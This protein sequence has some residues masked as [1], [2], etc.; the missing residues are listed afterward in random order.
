M[1]YQEVKNLD[2]KALQSELLK[3]KKEY[4]NLRFQKVLGELSNTSRIREVKKN[5]ARIFTALNNVDQNKVADQNKVK[6]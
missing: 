3:Y 4:F 2:N 1:K 5:I 6:K